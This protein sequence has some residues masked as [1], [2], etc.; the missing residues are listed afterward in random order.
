[1][2]PRVVAIRHSAVPSQGPNST[3][4]ITAKVTPGRDSTTQPTTV[5]TQ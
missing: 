2:A 1:M 4:A 5:S 3:P